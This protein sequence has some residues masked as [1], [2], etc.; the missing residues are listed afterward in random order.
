MEI[1]SYIAPVVEH[2]YRATSLPMASPMP[3]SKSLEH[4]RFYAFAFCFWEDDLE[5]LR[6]RWKGEIND[7]PSNDVGG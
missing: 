6:P 4:G 5:D 7:D 3:L 2:S 1:L